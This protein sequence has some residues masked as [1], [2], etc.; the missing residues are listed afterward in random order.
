M[1]S[2]SQYCLNSWIINISSISVDYNKYC[3]I[4][5]VINCHIHQL[6]MCPLL[7]DI[8]NLHH[9]CDSFSKWLQ[10]SEHHLEHQSLLPKPWVAVDGEMSSI[11][12]VQWKYIHHYLLKKQK[13]WGQN[14][15]KPIWSLHFRVLVCFLGLLMVVLFDRPWLITPIR[16][17]LGLQLNM[18]TVLE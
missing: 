15:S 13:Q 14:H 9:G 5:S 17:R 16:W 11:K 2:L 4:T 12:C 1:P 18:A 3:N 8:R 6:S 7:Y 10:G